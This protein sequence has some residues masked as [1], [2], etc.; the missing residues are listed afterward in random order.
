MDVRPTQIPPID[1]KGRN[2]ALHQCPGERLPF[3]CFGRPPHV[4][5]GHN[6]S[7]ASKATTKLFRG[8]CPLRRPDWPTLTGLRQPIGDAKPPAPCAAIAP[9]NRSPTRT[10]RMPPTLRAYVTDLTNKVWC[11]RH[12]IAAMTAAPEVVGAYLAAAGAWRRGRT[13]QSDHWDS[14][15][16]P[17]QTRRRGWPERH[18]G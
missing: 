12:G 14:S 1:S 4:W 7:Y 16:D 10:L 6:R 3:S 8:G 9:P 15:P 5:N 18:V 13:R 11:D 2:T 17:P